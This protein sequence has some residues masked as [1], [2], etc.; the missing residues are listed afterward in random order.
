[1]AEQPPRRLRA[2]RGTAYE[3]AGAVA[4]VGRRS[5]SLDGLLSRLRMRQGGFVTAWNP[6]GHRMP[7]RWNQ[8]MQA[9]LCEAARR[10]PA[11]AGHG[12]GRTSGSGWKEAHL[13]LG[14]GPG[15]LVVLARRFRQAGVVLVRQGQ[16]A[17]LLLL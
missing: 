8:R 16:P 5:A 9:R 3:A 14:G 13:L 4:R 6:H 11:A 1:M 10:L 7:L 12:T 2:W 15:R 17:R